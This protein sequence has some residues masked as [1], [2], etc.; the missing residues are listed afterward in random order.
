MLSYFPICSGFLFKLFQANDIY[1]SHAIS[2]I[3][4]DTRNSAFQTYTLCPS[5]AVSPIPST[6]PYTHAV[7]LPL[8]ISTAAA[9]LFKKDT[10]ALPLNLSITPNPTK[11]SVLVWG[12]S[13]SVGCSAI[14]LAAAAGVKVVTVAGKHNLGAMKGLGASEAFDYSS[15]AVVDDVIKALEGTEFLGICDCIGTFDTAQAWGPVYKKLGGRYGSVM[16]DPHGLPEGIEG[17]SVFAPSVFLGDRYVG[18]AVWGK[19][20]PE[21]LEKGTFKVKPEPVVVLKGLERIQEAVDRLKKGISF[22]KVVV[23]L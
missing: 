18:G 15:S 21:S 12:G 16:P 11:K 7:V 3:T 10:L 5:L 20:I 22:G 1:N 9:C 4:G 23:E 17:T 8:S 2:L 13:S 19:Y 14:Q 6:L